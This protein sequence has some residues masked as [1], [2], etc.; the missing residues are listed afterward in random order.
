MPSFL[1]VS[2]IMTEKPS[3]DPPT[4]SA[5][6]TAM[7]FADLTIII[8]R[9]LSTVSC[10]PGRNPIFDGDCEAAVGDT[11]SSVSSV[12]LPSFTAFNVT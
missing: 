1:A 6:T 8:F 12:S 3:I 4:P 11:V 2:F 7:S 5:S 9:A 10:V